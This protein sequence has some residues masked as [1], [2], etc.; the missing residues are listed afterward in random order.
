MAPE[1]NEVREATAEEWDQ[2]YL[3]CDYATYFHS[4]EW[5]EIWMA[6]SRGAVNPKPLL[7]RFSDGQEVILP[8]SVRT[9]WRGV[10]EMYESSPAG[11][12]GGWI[13]RGRITPVHARLLLNYLRRK[14]DGLYFRA[15]PFDDTTS[16]LG[17]GA[18]YPD[19]T[20]VLDLR[21]GFDAVYA[22]I[23]RGHK[24]AANKATSAGVTIEQASGPEDWE[25]YYEVYQDS[26]RRWGR[27]ATSKYD[28]ALFSELQ[29]RKSPSIK[30]WIARYG[31]QIISGAVCFYSKT[32]AVYWHG[33]ALETYF[34]LR[35]PTLLM[36]EIIKAACDEKRL[37][38]DF[39]P[40]GGHKGVQVFKERFGAKAVSC[41]S[42]SYLSFR[43]RTAY[44]T[45]G[46]ARRLVKG[47]ICYYN[48][49]KEIASRILRAVNLRNVTGVAY[50]KKRAKT[51]GRRSVLNLTHQDEDF[52]SVTTR[53]ARQI[54]PHFKN[55]LNG[56]ETVIL[57]LG[58]GVGR[59]SVK[60]AECTQCHVI[61]VDP[62]KLL[63]NIAPHHER[64]EYRVM[65]SGSLPIPDQSVDVVWIC[66][67][68]G[69]IDEPALTRTICEIHR[70]LR[71]S[72]LL[73]LVE[74]TTEKPS[75]RYWKFRSLQQYRALLPFAPLVHLHDFYDCADRLSIMAGRKRG[76]PT[77]AKE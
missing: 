24:S 49:Q 26:I 34:H 58:C 31:N 2:Y 19:V 66:L 42:V 45:S 74:G 12:F 17:Q 14:K 57:D 59:F 65:E 64:V 38:F 47:A 77:G 60:L 22:G 61:A 35:A 76:A 23:S 33:A 46:L 27:H 25:E 40:S 6:Y 56:S 1:I 48:N 3:E 30:L 51:Y 52:D 72:G 9:V 11:T 62:V 8:L 21:E 70:V 4:R 5:A 43:L 15:N 39:N 50:W 37:W 44:L 68:F 54:F 41:P 67:V 7:V 73:F 69:A 53:Q 36:R 10:L 18:A 32:H 71:D 63:L 16:S 55:Q 29:R 13:S 28:R 20:H 75:S